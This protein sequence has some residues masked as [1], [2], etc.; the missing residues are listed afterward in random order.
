[1]WNNHPLSQTKVVDI[2]LVDSSELKPHPEKRA[3]LRAENWVEHTSLHLW[4][5]VVEFIFLILFVLLLCF[6]DQV[7]GELDRAFLDQDLKLFGYRDDLTLLK[8][9]NCLGWTELENF[10]INMVDVFG[11]TD[12]SF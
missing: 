4:E 9:L 2:N 10:G 7:W 3:L 11:E 5:L 12:V 6:V 8:L 1:V